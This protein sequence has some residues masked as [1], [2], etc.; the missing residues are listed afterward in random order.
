[1]EYTIEEINNI[2]KTNFQGDEPYVVTKMPENDNTDIYRM[3]VKCGPW[4][5]LKGIQ[6][7]PKNETHN[8][9]LDTRI[10]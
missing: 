4:Y 2:Y 8:L 10:I 7:K 5:F 9:R 1:M 3:F 6:S